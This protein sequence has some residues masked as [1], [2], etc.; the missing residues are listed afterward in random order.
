MQSLIKKMH[1]IL[2]LLFKLF[3]FCFHENGFNIINNYLN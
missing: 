1:N 2:N 3:Y